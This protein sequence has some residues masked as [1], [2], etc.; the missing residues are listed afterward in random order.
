ML[1]DE[2][3]LI[4][5]EY[6]DIFISDQTKD[7]EER[8]ELFY[9][10]SFDIYHV[11]YFMENK[12]K[13]MPLLSK[14]MDDISI[15]AHSVFDFK[16]LIYFAQENISSDYDKNT[17]QVYRQLAKTVLCDGKWTKYR[18][19]DHI[20]TEDVVLMKGLLDIETDTKSDFFEGVRIVQDKFALYMANTTKGYEDRAKLFDEISQFVWRTLYCNDGDYE[21]ENLLEKYMNDASFFAHTIYDFKNLMYF[22]LDKSNVN[23]D[24]QKRYLYKKLAFGLFSTTNWFELIELEGMEADEAILLKRLQ[25]G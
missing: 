2:E 22:A 15:F 24:K 8:K 25:Y 18:E 20:S 3:M 7:F 21:Y 5:G 1:S 23:I 10:I 11:L 17:H 14:Y 6:H 12:Q 16:N 19:L 9:K 4:S 13:Y